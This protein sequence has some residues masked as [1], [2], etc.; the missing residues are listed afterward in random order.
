MKAVSGKWNVVGMLLKIKNSKDSKHS[1]ASLITLGY[2]SFQV[3]VTRDKELHLL[4]EASQSQEFK[5]F[6]TNAFT[7]RHNYLSMCCLSRTFNK[8]GHFIVKLQNSN[9]RNLTS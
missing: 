5:S 4:E 3:I 8:N 7:V 6:E 1:K 2:H 9:S